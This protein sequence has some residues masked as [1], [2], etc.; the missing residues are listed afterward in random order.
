MS[1]QSDYFKNIGKHATGVKTQLKKGDVKFFK[2]FSDLFGAIMEG[3]TCIDG[4]GEKEEKYR[5]VVSVL[6]EFPG[7]F[8]L[9]QETF[10]YLYNYAQP[11]YKN[12]KARNAARLTCAKHLMP[13]LKQQLEDVNQFIDTM[14]KILK[15][16]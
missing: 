2:E 10:G 7:V 13:L 12:P 16:K 4:L 14:E 8:N 3:K 5:K 9:A 1:V 11:D 6:N 15:P